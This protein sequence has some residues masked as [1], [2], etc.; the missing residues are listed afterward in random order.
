M[1]TRYS[2]EDLP[3][4]M[5]DREREREKVREIRANRTT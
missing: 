3:E 1:D 4:D 2:P 5:N